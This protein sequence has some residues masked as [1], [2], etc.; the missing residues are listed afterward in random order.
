MS[1]AAVIALSVFTA[2]LVLGVPAC[3]RWW[4]S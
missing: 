1:Y 3:N 2:G 4:W